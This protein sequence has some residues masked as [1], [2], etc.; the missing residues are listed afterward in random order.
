MALDRGVGRGR[1]ESRVTSWS[2]SAWDFP[3]FRTGSPRPWE[4]GLDGHDRQRQGRRDGRK[5]G[6]IGKERAEVE[7][8]GEGGA[9]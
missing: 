1:G 8:D 3:G 5:E 9:A 7:D 4:N 2:R 6:V